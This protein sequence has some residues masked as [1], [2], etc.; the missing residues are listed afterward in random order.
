[1]F[2]R[3]LAKWFTIGALLIAFASLVFLTGCADDLLGLGEV[4]RQKTY[5]DQI[6]ASAVIGAANAQRDAEIGKAQAA[7]DKERILAEAQLERERLR[8]ESLALQARL[9]QEQENA[10]QRRFQENLILFEMVATGNPLVVAFTVI[11]AIIIGGL[12]AAR[13]N[14]YTVGIRREG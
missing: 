3:F 8:Q 13:I 4:A 1:M 14:G 2:I 7:V 9:T 10:A 6:Q 12:I 11:A 5:Q